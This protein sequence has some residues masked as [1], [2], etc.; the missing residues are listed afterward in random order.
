MVYLPCFCLPYET[1][2][3]EGNCPQVVLTIDVLTINRYVLAVF[4]L[5][6]NIFKITLLAINTY[7]L[8]VLCVLFRIYSQ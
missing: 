4:I 2:L 3:G 6:V 5:A 7:L 1:N 8:Y